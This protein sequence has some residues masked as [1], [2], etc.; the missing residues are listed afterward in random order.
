MLSHAVSAGKMSYQVYSE[1]AAWHT[2][3]AQAK[4][5]GVACVQA[6]RMVKQLEPY[7]ICSLHLLLR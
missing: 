2:L 4:L 6:H 5:L 7:R 1:S 3:L